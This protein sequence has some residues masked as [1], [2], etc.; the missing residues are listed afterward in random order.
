MD[1]FALRVANLLVGNEE[2][3]AAMEATVGGPKLKALQKLGVGWPGGR[4][5]ALADVRSN[6]PSSRVRG[7][8]R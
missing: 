6:T 8:K 2:G 5:C 4:G 3:D 7:H 1:K